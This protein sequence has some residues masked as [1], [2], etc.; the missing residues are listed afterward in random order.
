MIDCCSISNIRP[1][2]VETGERQLHGW[3]WL[4][5]TRR[6]HC[7][8]CWA[9][10]YVLRSN[11]ANS[12]TRQEIDND[13]PSLDNFLENAPDLDATAEDDWGSTTSHVAGSNYMRSILWNH[14]STFHEKCRPHGLEA[15]ANAVYIFPVQLNEL[16][17]L[18]DHLQLLARL[19]EPQDSMKEFEDDVVQVLEIEGTTV[20]SKG[21]IVGMQRET[22]DT[23]CK[24]KVTY[25]FGSHR[26]LLIRRP[27]SPQ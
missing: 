11:K 23:E 8:S 12:R 18:E 9:L 15:T 4:T 19:F 16:R 22:A 20:E 6:L 1:K 14:F 10:H 27:S 24:I 7:R 21:V 2:V 3:T 26:H 5:F 13:E 17:S 25:G